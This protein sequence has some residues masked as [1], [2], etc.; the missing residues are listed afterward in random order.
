MKRSYTKILITLILSV[1]WLINPIGIKAQNNESANNDIDNDAEETTIINDICSYGLNVVEINTENGEEPTCEYVAP[2]PSLGATGLGITNATKVPSE[3]NIYLPDGTLAYSSGQYVKGVSGATV[4]IRGNTSAYIPKKPYKIKLQKK[5]DLLLRENKDLTDKN[6]ALITD[7]A[8]R[9]M[10][11]YE[12]NRIVGLPWSPSAC[13]VNVVINGEYRG[14]YLLVETVERNDK[15]RLNVDKNTGFI[16][17]LDAYWWNEDGYFLSPL[18]NPMFNYTL[19]YPDYEDLTEDQAE[20]I[21]EYLKKYDISKEEGTFDTTIDVESVAKWLLGHD[22]LGTS[23]GAGANMY[24]MKY[25]NTPD[26]R[27]CMANMWDFDSSYGTPGQWSP[28]HTIRFRH[29]FQGDNKSMIREYVR[30]WKEL[31]PDYISKIIGWWSNFLASEECAGLT[32]SV[33]ATND[34]WDARWS[35]PAQI[36]PKVLQWH[37]DR[38]EWMD[39]MVA[40]MEET[41]VDPLSSEGI[42]MLGLPVLEIITDANETPGYKLVSKPEFIDGDDVKAITDRTEIRGNLNVLDQTSRLILDGDNATGMRLSIYGSKEP[43]KEGTAY[44]LYTDKILNL[45]GSAVEKEIESGDIAAAGGVKGHKWILRRDNE[46]KE[47]ITY[48]L[49]NTEGLKNNPETIEVNLLLNGEYKGVYLLCSVPEDPQCSIVKLDPYWWSGDEY[50][51]SEIFHPAFNWTYVEPQPELD[52]DKTE[53]IN[54]KI[55]V[56][57]DELRNVDFNTVD[58]ESLLSLLMIHDITGTDYATVPSTVLCIDSEG[59]VTA[60]SITDASASMPEETNT[61]AG[62]FS[63][64]HHRLFRSLMEAGEPVFHNAYLDKWNNENKAFFN[65]IREYLLSYLSAS[66]RDAYDKS[67]ELVNKISGSSY[68]SRLETV[69]KALEFFDNRRYELN[70]E[71]SAMNHRSSISLN[72]EDGYEEA[73]ITVTGRNIMVSGVSAENKL[74]VYNMQG[75]EIYSGTDRSVEL[76]ERGA[77][78]V[79]CGKNVK[80]VVLK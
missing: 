26:T 22:L 55:A 78:I 1:S 54:E 69:G 75:N 67:V 73:E 76:T 79:R 49:N 59:N 28:L 80:K 56:I 7:A 44:N 37:I 74:T 53:E 64:V 41:L 10:E 29:F 38:K 77:Y 36:F 8:Y 71:F 27:L 63:D 61:P 9:H 40:Q 4:K 66:G 21:G 62:V 5:A 24:F 58:M 25:D 30:L 2:D 14:T 48:H 33:P 20:Y 17:E 43:G 45:K 52:R 60:G 46:L 47:Q 35:T 19:K 72:P 42:A 39:Q 6:W 18:S 15:A 13:N 12:M 70:R 51:K 68:L 57:E 31:S 50:K 11:G 65:G 16:A 3:I 34:R 32:K 23:D